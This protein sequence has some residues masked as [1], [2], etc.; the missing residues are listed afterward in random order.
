VATR[1]QYFS[2]V[3]S[4]HLT[5][6]FTHFNETRKPLNTSSPLEGRTEFSQENSY[7]YVETERLNEANANL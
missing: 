2:S 6:Q 1:D 7:G 5:R 3:E 4:R